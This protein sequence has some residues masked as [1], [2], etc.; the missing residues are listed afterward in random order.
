[1]GRLRRFLSSDPGPRIV[2]LYASLET[3]NKLH[4]WC[5]KQG[6]DLTRNYNGNRIPTEEFDFHCTVIACKNSVHVPKADNR[7]KPLTLKPTGF[8]VLGVGRRVPTLKMQ[9]TETLDI[10]RQYFVEQAITEAYGMIPT[11]ET[12]KP[13]VSLSYN[14]DG[15]PDLK[16]LKLPTFDI[17]LDRMV[18]K[19][20]EP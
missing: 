2:M 19:E 5:L 6:F 17:I 8:E 16:T 14:W 12:F 3:Q 15:K 9:T 10:V 7:M 1:M 18:I 13:H 4:D 20:F 11:F